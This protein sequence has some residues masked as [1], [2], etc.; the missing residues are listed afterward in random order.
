MRWVIVKSESIRIQNCNKMGLVLE[1]S[2]G[3][4]KV[5]RQKSWSRLKHHQVNEVKSKIHEF[6]HLV[7]CEF[8]SPDELATVLITDAHFINPDPYP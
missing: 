6:H 2:V 4:S 5:L 1:W 3:E 8:P 7:E